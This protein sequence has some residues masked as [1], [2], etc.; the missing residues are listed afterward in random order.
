LIARNVWAREP[1]V[2]REELLYD[3]QNATEKEQLAKIVPTATGKVRR[4]VNHAA[5]QEKHDD[6]MSPL[7]FYKF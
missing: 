1:F 5:A 4:N 2:G 7:V 6:S 3:A